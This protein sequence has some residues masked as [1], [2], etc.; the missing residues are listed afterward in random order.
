MPVVACTHQDQGSGVYLAQQWRL[1][2]Q[3]YSSRGPNRQVVCVG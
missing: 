3:V 2:R 1:P